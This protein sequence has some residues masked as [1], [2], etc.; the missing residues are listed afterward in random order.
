MTDSIPERCPEC[1]GKRD[2]PRKID[3]LMDSLGTPPPGG[4]LVEPIP[5]RRCRNTFH[6]PT[7]AVDEEADDDFGDCG[8]KNPGWRSV[9]AVDEEEK[10][11]ERCG[12]CGAIT[13]L[14]LQLTAWRITPTCQ[15]RGHDVAWEDAVGRLREIYD[16]QLARTDEPITLSVS[17][18]RRTGE[19]HG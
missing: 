13:D 6:S 5:R 12:E 11:G 10:R 14:G 7:P 16:A 15:R 18:H 8:V 1:G 19:H 2:K 17:I 3:A 9:P 4:A